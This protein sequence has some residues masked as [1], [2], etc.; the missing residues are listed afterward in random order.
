MG[1]ILNDLVKSLGLNRSELSRKMG[2]SDKYFYSLITRKKI[3]IDILHQIAEITG[4][5]IY[6]HFGIVR[7]Y[8]QSILE[9][10]V[11]NE[12]KSIY[13]AKVIIK[14]LNQKLS[15]MSEKYIKAL[16]A[17]TARKN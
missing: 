3:D 10:M 9:S 7:H 13:E 1:E 16:E 14:S 17:L 8:E 4:I 2:K 15:E 6:Q 5:D 12:P 11:S